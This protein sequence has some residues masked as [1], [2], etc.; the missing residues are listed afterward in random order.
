MIVKFPARR[1]G[2]PGKEE[3]NYIAPLNPAYKAGLRVRPRSM[4][5]AF[6]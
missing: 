3:F 1:A 5:P 2:L 4:L 6:L